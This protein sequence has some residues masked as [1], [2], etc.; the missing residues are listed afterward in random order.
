VYVSDLVVDLLVRLGCRYVPLTPGASFRGLH[1]SLVSRRAHGDIDLLLCLHEEAAVAAAHGYAKAKGSVGVAMVHNLVGLMH[2]SMAVYNAWRDRAP[3]LVLGGSGP[4]QESARR[5]IEWIHAA[6]DQG[7]L[8]RDFVKWRSEPV[9]A[10]GLMEAI[11]RGHEIATTPPWGPVYISVD[12]NLQEQL[13]PPDLDLSN[14]LRAGPIP[15][16]GA[17][18]DHVERAASWLVDAEAPTILAGPGPRNAHYGTL[19]EELAEALGA[20][21]VDGWNAVS[22]PTAHPLAT[23]SSALRSADV[24]L[25]V[26]TPDADA[27]LAGV[28]GQAWTTGATRPSRVIDLRPPNGHSSWA[29]AEGPLLQVDLQLA[30]DTTTGL[31]QLLHAVE[32]RVSGA[33]TGWKDARRRRME[34]AHTRRQEGRH[35]ERAAVRLSTNLCEVNER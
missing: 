31:E 27:A 14:F 26:D 1:D 2:A 10:F 9:D 7:E 35:R 13:A 6:S 32:Q 15:L 24:L 16:A 5:P 18:P 28:T 22:F 25:R 33:G 34:L 19:L 30:A 23:D 12:S 29:H 11:V 3:V 20:L 17:H 4:R 21:C 8:V